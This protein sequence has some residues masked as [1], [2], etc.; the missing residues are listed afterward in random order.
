MPSQFRGVYSALVTPMSKSGDIDF[1]KLAAFSEYLAN[2]GVHGLTPLGSTGE[3]YALSP[4]ERT[5]VIQTVLD[6]VGDQIPVVPG[7]NASSTREVIAF[8]KQAEKMGC[9]AVMLAAPYYSLP[10]PDELFAHF[11]A[12]N[13]AIGVP[14]ML[15][16]YPGR[17]GVDMSP[18][19]VARLAKLKNVRYIKES[20]GEMPRIA[21]LKRLCGDAMGVFCG[22]DTIALQAFMMGA[23]GWT[24]GVVNP[25]PRCHV[26][27]FE[28]SMSGQ[29]KAA[30]AL[31]EKFLPV[32]ELMEGGGRYTCWVK[33]ACKIMGHDVG[34]PRGPLGPAAPA[35]IATLKKALKA[36]A[37]LEKQ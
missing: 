26:Q 24:G 12:V 34:D 10:T 13:D 36:C 35:E 6:A 19:F 31:Y 11:K 3:F 1:K 15:Y 23:I 27:L 20:T 8:S 37:S 21:M 16:N 14:I 22:C 30:Q 9:P 32:L 17:T 7:T 33:A 4:E 28:L 29:W 18:E 25:L 2:A 5:K